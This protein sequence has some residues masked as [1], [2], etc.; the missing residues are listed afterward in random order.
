M[1]GRQDCHGAQGIDGTYDLSRAKS[2][3]GEVHALYK[4]AAT[5]P[6]RGHRLVL[7][8][9]VLGGMTGNAIGDARG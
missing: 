1:S 7:P 4:S 9:I 2:S 5:A 3:L 8:W 6:N